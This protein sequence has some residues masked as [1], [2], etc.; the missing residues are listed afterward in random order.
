MHLVVG[1]VPQLEL[2]KEE[3]KDRIRGRRGK[4]I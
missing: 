2:R 3:N 1:K 4:Q